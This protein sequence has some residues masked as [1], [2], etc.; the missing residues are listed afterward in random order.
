MDN[1]HFMADSIVRFKQIKELADR[2]LA[3]L[4]EEQFFKSLD[5]DGNSPAILVKHLSGNL[6][7]RWNDLARY[8]LPSPIVK[9]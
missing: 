2:S 1:E 3:R 7:S 8:K 4:S 5:W 9:E 6:H